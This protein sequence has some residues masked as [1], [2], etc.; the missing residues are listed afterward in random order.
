MPARILLWISSSF[1]SIVSRHSFSG[2][3][4]SFD[5]I[6]CTFCVQQ[7]LK[8]F[9]IDETFLSLELIRKKIQT[10]ITVCYPHEFEP[11]SSFPLAKQEL[12]AKVA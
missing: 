2:F 8:G 5:S 1:N 11:L 6:L 7:N 10:N 4:F 12:Q 3:R 9:F